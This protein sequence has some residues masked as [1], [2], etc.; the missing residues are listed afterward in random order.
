M[1]QMSLKL[2]TYVKSVGVIN[3]NIE[4][5]ILNTIILFFGV[6]TFFYILF[7]G[8][9]VKNII[10]RQSLEVRM[11]SLANEVRSLE[12]AYLSMSNKVDLSLSYSMGF[13]E[14]EAI[15]ATR[16]SFSL[17]SLDSRLKGNVTGEFVDN[18]KIAQNDL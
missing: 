1:R 5:T 18:V 8:N 13:K 12:V 10:E 17:S 3:N 6:L 16:K 14:T 9:M 15:F 11:R 4:R 7:L 2:N